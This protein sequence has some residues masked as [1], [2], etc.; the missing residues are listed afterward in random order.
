MAVF[1][2]AAVRAALAVS[3]TAKISDLGH[4][5]RPPSFTGLVIV[6]SATR[7]QN[8][9]TLICR[10]AAPSRAIKSGSAVSAIAVR[11]TCGVEVDDGRELVAVRFIV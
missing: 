10:I 7:R 6:P 1:F 5:D 3:I 9:G 8:V 2:Y 4:L 11:L